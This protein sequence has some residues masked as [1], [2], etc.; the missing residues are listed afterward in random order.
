MISAACRVELIES[1]EI[2]Q[3][4]TILATSQPGP[5]L[6]PQDLPKGDSATDV[7]GNQTQEFKQRPSMAPESRCYYVLAACVPE[8]HICS[9]AAFTRIRG[10]ETCPVLTPSHF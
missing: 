7:L 4:E 3:E 8:I 2:G 1:L 9:S 10:N 6:H 5:E